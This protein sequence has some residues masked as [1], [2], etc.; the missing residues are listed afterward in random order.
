MTEYITNEN[1][2][3]VRNQIKLKLDYNNPYYATRA[4]AGS[5]ITDMDN[6]PYKRFFRSVYYESEPTVMEREAGYRPRDD[7]CYRLLSIPMS[8]KP[9][10][11]WEYPCSTVFPCTRKPN[12]GIS[13][14]EASGEDNSRKCT[15]DFI[16]SP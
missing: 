12:F 2:N 7:E 1:I 6:F 11:C 16:I 4:A 8:I 14:Q 10:Y 9:N 5:V 15:N 13:K 3:N